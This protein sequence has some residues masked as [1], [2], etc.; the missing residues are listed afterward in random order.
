M[1]TFW[2]QIMCCSFYI[3]GVIVSILVSRA[4]NRGFESLMGQTKDYTICICCLS[5]THDPHTH[6]L[7][8]I[9]KMLIHLINSSL[10]HMLPQSDTLSWFQANQSLLSNYALG[11]NNHI[12]TIVI[13]LDTF[14][15]SSL[16]LLLFYVCT[17]QI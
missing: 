12:L 6:T 14:I 8:W 13:I 16:C 4:I 1:T 15:Y 9:L 7:S 2:T 17:L 3:G 5:A 10:K 11:V